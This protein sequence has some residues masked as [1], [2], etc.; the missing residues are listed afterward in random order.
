MAPGHKLLSESKLGI[1]R[2]TLPSLLFAKTPD[3]PLVVELLNGDDVLKF[4]DLVEVVPLLPQ[5]ACI[6][7]RAIRKHVA[8]RN[9]LPFILTPLFTFNYLLDDGDL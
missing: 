4:D 1:T 3:E 5:D 6:K 2:D 7:V 8:N 9:N